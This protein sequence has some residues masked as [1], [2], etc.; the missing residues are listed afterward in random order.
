MASVKWIDHGVVPTNDL[1]H[2]VLFYRDVLGADIQVLDSIST[3]ALHYL[4]RQLAATDRARPDDSSARPSDGGTRPEAA[5]R[6][7]TMNCF[8]RLGPTRFGLFLQREPLPPVDRMSRTP[9]YEWAIAEGDLPRALAFFDQY[10]VEHE[11]P[12]RGADEY[13]LAQQIFFTDLDGNHA[14]LCVLRANPPD[15]TPALRREVIRVKGEPTSSGVHCVGA[16][17]FGSTDLD[18]SEAVGTQILGL[19]RAFRGAGPSGK[20]EVVLRCPSGQLMVFEEVDELSPR[21]SSK[22][23]GHHTALHVEPWDY[24]A[25]R[26]QVVAHKSLLSAVRL[27]ER[28]DV[29]AR[30]VSLR[31]ASDEG[32]QISSYDDETSALPPKAFWG[33]NYREPDDL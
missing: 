23:R 14:A 2:A 26:D 24:D 22:A 18:H 3:E 8:M 17:R 5:D 30:S 4:A 21:T 13:P 16:V 33:P 32:I 20:E 1:G 25:L 28:Y 29:E 15:A 11:L 7:S 19:E 12:I 27:G 9:C 31:D 10:E 6:R